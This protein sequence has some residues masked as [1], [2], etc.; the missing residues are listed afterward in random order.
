MIWQ[1][2][3][4]RIQEKNLF[5]ANIAPTVELHP[6]FSATIR[7]K[8]TRRNMWT[9]RKKSREIGLSYL[10]SWK[11]ITILMSDPNKIYDNMHS[12]VTKI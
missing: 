12:V 9:R 2:T 6:P 1:S 4:E 10:L 11:L 5:Y 8:Y 3:G 7:D